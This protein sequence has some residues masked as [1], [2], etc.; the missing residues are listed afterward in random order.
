M[1]LRPM[2]QDFYR[3]F[4]IGKNETTITTIDADGVLMAAIQELY[5]RLENANKRNE[6][7]EGKVEL[8][9]K[10]IEKLK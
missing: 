8:L 6:I 7:L 4:E 3:I 1:Y 2:A 10:E 5:Q 9:F